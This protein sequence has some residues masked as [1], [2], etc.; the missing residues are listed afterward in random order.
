MDKSILCLS[1]LNGQVKAVSAGNG[2]V[3]KT[4]ARPDLAED[5]SSFSTILR[6]AALATDYVGTD[7][8]VVLSHPRLTQ[9]LVETPPLRGWNLRRF[10]D[11][12]ARQLKTFTTEAVF[13]YQPTLPTKNA[14]AVL[15]HLF[16]KPFLD[17]MVQGCEQ[18]DLRLSKVFPATAVLN[19]QFRELPVDGDE[20]VLV[21]A[22]TGGNTTVVIGRKDG[23]I[24]LGR[25]LNSSWNIYPDRVNVDL[26]R[27]LLYVKQ[28]FGAPVDNMWL[29]GT[30]AGGHADAMEALVKVPIKLSPIPYSPFY[31]NEQALKLPFGDT[32]NL[33]SAEL[34]EAP[35]RRVLLRA[36]AII[37]T[38]LAV[39]SL[40]LAACY[41][42]LVSDRLAT[43]TKLKPKLEQLQQKKV[44]LSQR[45]TELV[46]HKQ[47]V[48]V[49]SEQT[50]P[51]VPGWFLGYLGDA[52]PEDLFLS[53]L[54]VKREDDL[55]FFE[56]RGVLEPTAT[57]SLADAITKLTGNLSNGPFHAKITRSSTQGGA[58]A[59]A[60]SGSSENGL[61]APTL[62]A[63]KPTEFSIEGV[64]R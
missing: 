51:A 16:P 9:Q 5:F 47:F 54:N 34:H 35:K 10:L 12:Q 43:Y 53:Q 62:A 60:P 25:T 21:A 63:D 31:W 48:N 64:M 33:V 61:P 15:L 45:E 44:Q 41:Q 58:S 50:V 3:L 52:V 13:S 28:Q 37:I 14:K 55:W 7:V 6:E 38:L 30:G 59:K 39:A 4:W 49:V 27:T 36:T 40:A 8:E 1:W 46:Q 56:M 57:N 20:V 23:Q 2:A 18:A 19:H 32:N 26:N 42:V 29:V 11:R 24:Y 22:E 17:Q